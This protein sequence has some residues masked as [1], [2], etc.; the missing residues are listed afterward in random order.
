MA[1]SEYEKRQDGESVVFTVTPATPPIFWS[2]VV[3]ILICFS[4]F[5]YLVPQFFRNPFEDFFLIVTLEMLLLIIALFLIRFFWKGEMRPKA[6]R[7]T[8]IFRVSPDTIEANGRIFNK[9][10]IHRL[11]I[12]NGITKN[13]L[14]PSHV[15]NSGII[16]SGMTNADGKLVTDGGLTTAAICHSLELQTG[17]KAYFLAGGMDETTAFG[18]HKDVSDVIG[19]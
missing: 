10:D 3:A 14:R 1:G 16:W 4:I 5:M 11:H 7:S 2:A 17:G 19:L 12:N 9:K 8:S 15:G 13:V 18:L 6:H